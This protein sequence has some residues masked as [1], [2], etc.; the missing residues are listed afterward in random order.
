MLY[1]QIIDVYYENHREHR[2]IERGQNV[3][4]YNVTAG[5]S[6]IYR[7]VLKVN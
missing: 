3:D 2:N 5:Y 1:R 6:Y 7:C 4:L